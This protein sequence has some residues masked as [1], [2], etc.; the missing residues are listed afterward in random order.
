MP[1]KVNQEHKNQRR[2]KILKAAEAVFIENGYEK[3]TMKDVMDKSDVSRGGLYQY[4]ANKEDLFEA[5]ISEDATENI[6][7]S[8]EDM[9]KQKGSYWDILLVTFLGEEKKPTN[10]MDPLAPSKL[11]FFITRRNETKRKDHAK[12]R[13]LQFYQMI[14]KIIEAGVKAG[15]FSP[16]FDIGVISKS[17]ISYTDGLALDHAILDSESIQLKEQTELLFEYIRWAL[18]VKESK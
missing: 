2:S 12:Q 5:L 4:F 7:S 18:H 1:P 11:E 10:K 14:N 13:Y 8:L 3:T 16:R 9:V 6:D 15:E 17:I